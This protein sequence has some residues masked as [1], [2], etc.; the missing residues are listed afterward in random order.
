MRAED[1]DKMEAMEKWIAISEQVFFFT[2][3]EWLLKDYF[4]SDRRDIY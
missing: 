1:F 4:I 2:K 3:N